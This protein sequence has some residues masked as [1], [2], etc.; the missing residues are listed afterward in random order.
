MITIS[1]VKVS[2]DIKLAKIYISFLNNTIPI[3]EVMKI[4]IDKRNIIKHLLIKKINL[5]YIPDLRYFYDDSY[6]NAE[7][8]NKLINKVK[9]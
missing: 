2:K 5:K 7:K 3:D 4:I 9:S 6:E 1:K 8:I